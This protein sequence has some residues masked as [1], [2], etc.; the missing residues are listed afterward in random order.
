MPS[1]R[2]IQAI[3]AKKQVQ[4]PFCGMYQQEAEQQGRGW[5]VPAGPHAAGRES[6]QC[7]AASKDTPKQ[8][9][10]QGWD[11]AWPGMPTQLSLLA[12]MGHCLARG[13]WAA[14][15]TGGMEGWDRD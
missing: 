15:I 6:K 10:W 14:V 9:C 3:T 12:G 2:Q 4:R 1:W 7:C 11:T 5:G 13:I 8:S